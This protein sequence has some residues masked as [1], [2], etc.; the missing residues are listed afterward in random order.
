MAFLWHHMRIHKKVWF[1]GASI[2]HLTFFFF[3]SFFFFLRS[4][5][6]SLFFF[7]FLGSE[8]DGVSVRSKRWRWVL[9]KKCYIHYMSVETKHDIPCGNGSCGRWC[10][11]LC[12]LFFFGGC[13]CISLY[14][15]G[16]WKTNNN[17]HTGVYLTVQLIHV[18]DVSTW[19]QYVQL[20]N[21]CVLHSVNTGPVCSLKPVSRAPVRGLKEFPHTGGLS[22]RERKELPSWVPG[23]SI[24]PAPQK[25]K[26]KTKI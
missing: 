6:S 5:S 15:S 20:L 4:G 25:I 2:N 18:N 12:L 21:L 13:M 11:C 9:W 10:L 7:F 17:I 3:L 24:I 14:C 8:S 16:S 26:D 19:W 23:Q 1:T 22:I